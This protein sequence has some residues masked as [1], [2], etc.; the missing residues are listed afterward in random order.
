MP[1]LITVHLGYFW[2]K[3]YRLELSKIAKSSHTA[4]KFKSP[5]TCRNA[6]Y[7]LT[8]VRK[9]PKYFSSK[10]S[11]NLDHLCTWWTKLSLPE[12]T[13]SL[14]GSSS[15]SL[16]ISRIDDF[17]NVPSGTSYISREESGSGYPDTDPDQLK[18][19]IIACEP[20]TKI[21]LN[22]S[23]LELLICWSFN[24]LLFW[25]CNKL[26]LSVLSVIQK[27]AKKLGTF[28]D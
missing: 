24:W 12:L 25:C 14:T 27:G 16:A 11:C 23:E 8:R 5:I 13:S 26:C 18:V 10:Y 20:C 17:L 28:L 19:L 4:W 21:S 22:I 1:Q 9:K 15:S 2:N 7:K 3:L 6:I